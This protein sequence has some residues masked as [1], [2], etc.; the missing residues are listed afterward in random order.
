METIFRCELLEFREG[1]FAKNKIPKRFKNRSAAQG[2]HWPLWSRKQFRQKMPWLSTC[3]KST[4]EFSTGGFS[5]KFCEGLGLAKNLQ[6]GAPTSY[7]WSY[8]LYKWP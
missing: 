4:S 6:E 8:N 1:N 3:F 2:T 7:K 5:W